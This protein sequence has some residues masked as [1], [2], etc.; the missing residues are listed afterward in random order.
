MAE[1]EMIL[2]VG[3]PGAGKSTFYR[4]HFA[5]THMH[6]SKDNF[7]HNKDRNRRQRQLIEGAF[8]IGK[9]VVVD[10][11]HVTREERAGA[12]DVAR[13][14]GVPVRGYIFRAEVAECLRR[15]AQREGKARV[16]PVAIYTRAKRWEEPTLEEGFE[17][18][19]DATGNSGI[20]DPQR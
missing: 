10:N 20:A 4:R 8:K 6:V 9:P 15:N 1:L 14:A 18:L 5:G 7:R 17:W 2:F 11:T 12:I 16:A 13:D 19:K 3:L